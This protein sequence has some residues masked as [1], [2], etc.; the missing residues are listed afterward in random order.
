MKHLRNAIFAALIL[1]VTGCASLSTK[2]DRMCNEVADFANSSVDYAAHSVEL[3]TDFGTD[4]NK[5]QNVLFTWGCVDG[6]YAPGHKLCGYLIDHSSRENYPANFRR[7]LACIGA[8]AYAGSPDLVVEHLDAKISSYSS[9]HVNK[10]VE[11]GVELLSGSS[12]VRPLL[13]ITVQRFK[14]P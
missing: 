7:V 5:D 4:L 6:G 12:K 8:R 3:T 11:V 14:D 10:D 1:C 2:P 13:K 9:K